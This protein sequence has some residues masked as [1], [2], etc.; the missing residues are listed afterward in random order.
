MTKLLFFI[1]HSQLYI[2]SLIHSHFYYF[3]YYVAYATKQKT[4]KY[5]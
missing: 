1:S 4:E 5:T 2:D 3:S